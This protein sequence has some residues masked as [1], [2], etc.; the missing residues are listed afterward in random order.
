[1][2]ASMKRLTGL[3]LCVAAAGLIGCGDNSAECGEGTVLDDNGYCV[4]TG[5]TV[6]CT[7]GTK[8]DETTNTCVIDPEA[9]QSGTVLIDGACK[10]PAEGLVVDVTEAA[11]PNAL[12]FFG[13]P[14]DDP[15]GTFD[16]KPVGGPAVVVQG[17]FNP[18]ADRDDD[19]ELEPDFDT[20]LFQAN[21]PALLEISV[22]GVGGAAGAFAAIYGNDDFPAMFS[23][24]RLG[25]NRLGDT[26]KRQVYLPNAG[27]YVLIIADTRAFLQGAPVG[28]ENNKYFASIKQ[29]P[30][31]AATPLTV[32]DGVARA[33]DTLPAG[34]VKLYSVPLGNGLNEASYVADNTNVTGSLVVVQNGGPRVVVDEDFGPATTVFGG[35]AATDN[36][37]FVADQFS[38][39]SHQPT[40]I[41]LQVK[42]RTA[43]PLL[44]DGVEATATVE[45]ATDTAD[46]YPTSLDGMNAYTFSVNAAGETVGIDWSFDVPIDGTIVDQNGAIAATLSY[47][48]AAADFFGTFIDGFG[49]YQWESYK[50]LWRAPA[51]GR[52][53]LLVWGPESD[54]GDT[55]TLTSTMSVLT[56]ETLTVGTPLTGVTPN[57]YNSNPY[58]FNADNGVWDLFTAQADSASGG[59]IIEYMPLTSAF[60]ALDDLLV[61]EIGSVAQYISTDAS[62]LF[63]VGAAPGT[64]AEQGQV[65][66]NGPTQYF[67]KAITINGTGTFGFGAELR[68]FTDLGSHNGPY[69]TTLTDQ[70]FP[71]IYDDFDWHMAIPEHYYLLRTQPGTQ[72][73]ITVTP[74]DPGMDLLIGNMDYDESFFDYEDAEYLAPETYTYTADPSGFVAFTVWDWEEIGATFDLELT[75]TAPTVTAPYYTVANGTTAW[76]NACSGGV[77]VTPL[78]RDDGF[79]NAIPLPAGF[80]FFANAVTAIKISTNGWFTFD[81]T[82]DISAGASRTPQALPSATAPNNLVAAYWTNL[83]LVRICTKTVGTKFIVQW[84]GL[85]FGT[86]DVIA[87]QAILDTADD[88]IE[89]IQAPY[90][91]GTGV[92]AASG[93]ESASGSQGTRLFYNTAVNNLAGSSKKLTHQ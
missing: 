31:P 57:A 16:L 50:G 13:E 26:A 70:D 75:L 90:S 35:V 71:I 85:Q 25:V 46:F 54:L 44:T 27:V 84:R 83:E 60:G 9:C 12:G 80:D 81:S 88:S 34:E 82:A 93:V 53:Y 36:V 86:D 59:A 10:D 89:I 64:S 40:P 1:M 67:V 29:L 63:G 56:P 72:V 37:V 49:W 47:Y 32:T 5:G 78:N 14:S 42:V 45:N 21:G 74:N 61:S 43:A 22:D 6:T 11:E 18:Q 33:L 24:L 8:L 77:D 7:D 55:L 91:N 87:T 2:S 39:S 48:P 76:S 23:W 52:Y 69:T 4:A 92:G 66:L 62:T 58:V 28:D 15:A 79:T 3:L 41:D 38:N 17:N 30:I 20:Y 73:E 51:A 68:E 65:L 19:G